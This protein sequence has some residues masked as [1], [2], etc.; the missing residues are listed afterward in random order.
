MKR[1]TTPPSGICIHHS[2]TPD[3]DHLDTAAIRRYHIQANGWDD[4]GYHALVERVGGEVRVIPGRPMEFQGAHCPELNATHLGLCIVGNYDLAPPDSDLLD[5]AA[6]W[7]RQQME[8][9]GMALKDIAYHCDWSSKTCP[10]RQFPKG[11]F[12][13]ALAGEERP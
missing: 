5:A 9:Y 6:A 3:G 12:L 4:I 7:C 2:A 8:R 13:L 10:G 1:F 11:G